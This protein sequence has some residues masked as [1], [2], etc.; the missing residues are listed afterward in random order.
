[1]TELKLP[2]S[3]APGTDATIAVRPTDGGPE[4]TFKICAGVSLPERIFDITKAK[5]RG[6]E[7]QYPMINGVKA[8]W[9]VVSIT[10]VEWKPKK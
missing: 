10:P 5:H 4:R 3:A 8:G 6:P 2:I 1:M 7:H 9:E